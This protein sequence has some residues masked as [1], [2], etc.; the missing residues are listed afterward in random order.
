MRL[1]IIIPVFNK[2]ELTR[3]CL[4]S[5]ALHTP[6]DLPG[7]F[8][9]IL[10]DNAS[11]DA[12]PAEAPALGTALFGGAFSC[13]RQSENRNFAGACNAGAA[14]AKGEFLFFLNNDTLLTP[15]WLP[16]LLAAFDGDP[17]LGACG[18][19]L[20]YPRFYGMPDRVQH[21][22]VYISPT[23]TMGHLYKGFPADHPAVRKERKAQIITAAALLMPASLFGGAGRFDEGYVNGFEDA[24]L[25]LR[26]RRDGHTLK[27]LPAS[28]IYHLESQSPGRH[29][30]NPYNW[31]RLQE[32]AG[33]LLAPDL[34]V[35]AENDGFRVHI[36]PW[37]Y[38]LL[39]HKEEELA[40]LAPHLRTTDSHALERL[41][42]RYPLWREGY[43]RLAD[44]F[45]KNGD[46]AGAMRACLLGG[47]P[48]WNRGIYQ[49]LALLQGRAG[50][51][52]GLAETAHWLGGYVHSSS[53]YLG[54]ARLLRDSFAHSGLDFLVR[55]CDALM[56]DAP[57]FMEGQM[58]PFMRTLRDT[59]LLHGALGRCPQLYRAWTELPEGEAAFRQ[60]WLETR[61][62]QAAKITSPAAKDPGPLLSVLMPV[63]NPNHE[64]LEEA[65][66]SVRNQTYA[67]WEL[68]LA[69][70]ASPDPEILPILRRHAREDKR[71]KLMRR[72]ENGHI[73]AASNSALELAAGKFC[74]LMDHD[75]TLPPYALEVLAAA[76]HARP[77]ASVF[78]SDED[79]IEETYTRF[80]PHLKWGFDQELFLQQ[81]CLSHLGA[82]STALLRKIGGFRRGLEGSQDYD[83]ALRCIE[84][85]G[86]RGVV[87]IPLV[88]YH[89]RNH[90]G[91]TS[92]GIGAKNYALSAFQ[93]AQREQCA[94]QGRS[95]VVEQAP[96]SNFFRLRHAIPPGAG[97][98]LIFVTPAAA[99]LDPAP[100]RQLAQ[101]ALRRLRSLTVLAPEAACAPL[102]EGLGKGLPPLTVLALEEFADA[103]LGLPASHAAAVLDGATGAG[104]ASRALVRG[105]NQAL[106]GAKGDALGL[107]QPGLLPLPGAPEPDWASEL[108]GQA[109]RPE[110]GCVGAAL[111]TEEE[112]ILQSGRVVTADG[113]PHNI[114]RNLD[115]LDRVHLWR[116]NLAHTAVTLSPCGIFAARAK[117]REAGPW[118][119]DLGL[120]GAAHACLALHEKGLRSVCTPYAALTLTAGDE[121]LTEPTGGDEERRFYA[122][123][124]K[125]LL[126]HPISHPALMPVDTGFMPVWIG[127]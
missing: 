44:L 26:L 55:Q 107:L 58:R 61:R 24:E 9:V 97:L 54:Y 67:N 28:T 35:H 14:A 78:F 5:L 125:T 96:R 71:I 89:W 32:R 92:A 31:E 122:R 83:L 59:G 30:F 49:R 8:E 52:E 109:L 124:E 82:Y 15:D 126:R 99:P 94:R 64:F 21:V 17:S 50:D 33:G 72:K 105:I 86:H 16:P 22:G 74:V 85:C 88:L 18:P 13:L 110:I 42:L 11:S 117:W 116:H 39:D 68:C 113:R 27:V 81:N 4:E 53:G 87:H 43:C 56:A 114:Y 120:W 25:C 111:Y 69:D 95:A 102:R 23:R 73:S 12:T 80:Q 93:R 7:G 19:M 45:L 101:S 38:P 66:I 91:S 118:P 10:V 51:H 62:E 77:D 104:G 47:I 40:A 20:L 75:D 103:S 46:E 76:I 115:R 123:W 106:A 37:L 2:W 70:D 41:L 1:S 48:R 79:K 84:E 6:R 34:H 29:Q 100:L 112:I 36:D 119:E 60:L 108:L 98:G 57:R 121:I 63:Y 90:E 127:E 65:L 3:D